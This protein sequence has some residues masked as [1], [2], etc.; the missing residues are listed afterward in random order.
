MASKNSISLAKIKKQ[1]ALKNIKTGGKLNFQ[2]DASNKIFQLCKTANHRFLMLSFQ[3][4]PSEFQKYLKADMTLNSLNISTP[5]IIE[6]NRSQK[7]LLMKYYPTNNS[8]KY[9]KKDE[10]KNV[11]QLASQNIINL[12]KPRKKFM[13]IPIK[14]KSNLIKN[15]SQG[16]ETYIDYFD[17]KIQIGVYLNKL[18]QQSIK[19][20]LDILEKYKPTLTH[21]DYFLENLIFY[22]K[23]LFVID[24]QDLHYNHPYLDIASLIFDARRLYSPKIE[25]KLIKDYARKSYLSLNKFRYD[26]HLVS[27]ARNLRIL[28]NWV[29]L[30]RSGKPHY[31]KKF[32]KNTWL[33]ILKHVEHL[34]LWDLRE[35]FQEIY[36]KTK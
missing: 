3:N 34:R 30:Y 20:N 5:K 24:H 11:L 10:I 9:F 36:F 27:L 8:S 33:Q 23:E 4:N 12:Q 26:I 2:N 25:D 7:Y 15:A 35:L 18:I 13:G 1:L 32:R 17:H 19:K 16:I 29:S 31:L 28:G 6:K 21:G 22:K 14:S